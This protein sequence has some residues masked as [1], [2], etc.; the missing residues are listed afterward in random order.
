MAPGM[1]SGGALKSGPSKPQR[2]RALRDRATQ[3][4]SP[5]G[6]SESGPSP[7]P[8]YDA[9]VVAPQGDVEAAR[10]LAKRLPVHA[11]QV[12]FDLLG[13]LDDVGQGVGGLLLRF[14]KH[15]ADP[16]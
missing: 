12:G 14:R 8:R 11:Y 5:L 2:R 9:I 4:L 7:C 10:D 1:S 6:E 16:D 15:T 3:A 13:V